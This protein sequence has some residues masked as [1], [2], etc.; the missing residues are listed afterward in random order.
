[1]NIL[2]VY[3]L[4][5]ESFWSFKHALKFI[6]KKAAY[7][8]LGL[9]TVAALLPASWNKKLVDLNVSRLEDKDLIWADY[10]FISAMAIQRDSVK[11]VLERC[12]DL[13]VRTVAGGPLFTMEYESFP[14]VDHFVLN[15]G[16][17][18]LPQFL[19][20][21]DEGK[22]KRVYDAREWPDLSNT[23][24]PLWDL[25]NFKHYASMSIQFS[26]GCPYHCDFCNIT[27][28]FGKNPRL[29][30]AGR[31]IEELDSLFY[32]G[33]R[34]G[35]F[36]VDDNFIGNKN[37][38]KKNV[39]PALINWMNDKKHPFTLVTEASI[40]LA[41]DDNLLEMM[42]DAGFTNVFVGIETPS[43]EGLKECNKFQ[44]TN[45]GLLESVRK[46]QSFG[47][48]VSAG[49][50]VGFDSDTLTIFD[51]MISFIEQSGITTAMVGL[52]N[53]PQGTKLFKRLKEEKRLIEGFSGDNTDF[54]MNFIPKMDTHK[55]K[56]GY[57][58]IVTTIYSPEQYYNRITNF[59]KVANPKAKLKSSKLKF[60]YLKALCKATLILGILEK[61]RKHYWKMV[62]KTMFRYPK[63]LPEAITLAVYGFH[64]RKIF[65]NKSLDTIV[66][67]FK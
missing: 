54:F 30:G 58:R 7:P 47:I 13:G 16:E 62:F 26:R 40:N 52:L 43:E 3:P 45:R 5:S 38:I 56:E 42:R 22:A 18:T 63:R 49:F 15:E 55:L 25:I 29:K 9:L 34:G 46:I 51:R 28:L 4:Y 66:E 12:K 17:V 6:G 50:I 57:R 64:F 21:L 48:Q 67:I 59:L 20:D 1:M 37:V 31:L 11:E 19:M 8:P 61:G 23:P 14:E 44:N 24:I 65:N 35:V 36:I 53:A 10:V 32:R 60:Y 27:S 39:L 33:W 41:D 2:L